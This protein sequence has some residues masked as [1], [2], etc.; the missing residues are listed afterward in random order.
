MLGVRQP[1]RQ[2]RA[3][4]SAVAL[5][6]KI[7]Q[8][9]QPYLEPGEQ[10]QAVFAAQTFSQY[11]AALSW[12]I[13]LFKNA[14]RCV[15]V[16]DRRIAVFNTGRWKMTEPKELLRNLPRNT[17][18]GPATGLWYKTDVLGERLYIHKRFHKDIEA[19]DAA[20]PA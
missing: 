5:R 20:R 11:W 14:Y 4:V 12:L 2:L 1:R 13:V 6:D 18:L 9:V 17:Q 3:T 19:A 15:A 8:N 7:V 16:T 10:V